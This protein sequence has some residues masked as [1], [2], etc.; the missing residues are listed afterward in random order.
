[1][2]LGNK[3]T[4]VLVFIIFNLI[5]QSID[6]FHIGLSKQQYKVLPKNWN[7]ILCWDLISKPFDHES[8]PITTVPWAPG[9]Q[10]SKSNA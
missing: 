8:N 7:I 3:S 6:I 5:K 10:V 9:L 4:Q 2:F 1:M